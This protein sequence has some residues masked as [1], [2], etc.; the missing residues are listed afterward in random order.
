MSDN[1]NEE[2][3][4]LHNPIVAVS[5]L[6]AVVASYFIISRWYVSQ[7]PP[8]NENNQNQNKN[9]FEARMRSESQTLA[10]ERK[11]A[12]PLSAADAKAQSDY[13]NKERSADQP[14]SQT[15]L[16]EQAKYLNELRKKDSGQ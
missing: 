11:T 13:L 4:I 2:H 9:N 6:I 8:Q 12:K 7:S 3:K 1:K 10:E 5:I 16:D 15:T 14:L